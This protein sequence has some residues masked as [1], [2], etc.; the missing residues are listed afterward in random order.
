MFKMG[1]HP[2]GFN[3]RP[4]PFGGLR[5]KDAVYRLGYPDFKLADFCD[6]WIYTKPLS[7]YEGVTPIHDWIDQKNIDRA[8]MQIPDPV[9]RRASV[10]E[11]NDTIAIDADAPRQFRGLH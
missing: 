3:L 9:L 7:T 11:Y 1:P 4:G 5:I 2:I 8:R 10:R 6:G